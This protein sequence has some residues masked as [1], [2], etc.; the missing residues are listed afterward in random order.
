[1]LQAVISGNV[2]RYTFFFA[3]PILGAAARNYASTSAREKEM[4]FISSAVSKI[5]FDYAIF[6][7]I[8]ATLDAAAAAVRHVAWIRSLL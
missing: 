3:I 7:V 8:T 6:T 4:K 5:L 1:L 2:M